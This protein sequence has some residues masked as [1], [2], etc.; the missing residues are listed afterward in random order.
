MFS[1]AMT[2]SGRWLERAGTALLLVSGLYLSFH[3]FFAYVWAGVWNEGVL[4]NAV[5]IVIGL[6]FALIW[7]VFVFANKNITVY[8][9]GVA[10]S[11]GIAVT[12]V[13]ARFISDILVLS[14][15]PSDVAFSL[16]ALSL[17]SLRTRMSPHGFVSTPSTDQK[18]P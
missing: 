18:L 1:A 16:I 5:C 8:W 15:Q 11:G 6:F 14:P 13:W 4:Q 10:T 17:V 3:W 12:L 9:A 2:A 7:L